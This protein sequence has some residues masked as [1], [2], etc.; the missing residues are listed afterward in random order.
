MRSRSIKPSCLLAATAAAIAALVLGM[1]LPIRQA[2]SMQ[3]LIPPGGAI[4]GN[5]TCGTSPSTNDILSFGG[6]NWCGTANPTASSLTTPVLSITSGGTPP[7]SGL[8]VS[9]GNL[10]LW[11]SAANVEQCNGG[12]GNCLFTF[13]L[14]L[15]SL[16]TKGI[17]Y[18]GDVTNTA[19]PR[20]FLGFTA[21]EFANPGVRVRE[22]Y[23]APKAMTV[24]NC[25]VSYGGWTGCTTAPTYRLIDDTSTLTICQAAVVPGSPTN[26]LAV[27]PTTTAI[28]AGDVVWFQTSVAAAGCTQADGAA[29]VSLT[30]AYHMQ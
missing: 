28:A 20:M 22:T 15:G 6:T 27:T 29:T 13:G 11:S 12:T 21:A 8:N 1:C 9:G 4:Q 19:A 17:T 26:G 14:T 16:G 10:N 23:V 25:E 18:N 7:S 5:P 3:L 24:D 30:A 2:R